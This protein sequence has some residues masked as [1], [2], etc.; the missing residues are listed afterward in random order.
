MKRHP[1]PWIAMNRA[2]WEW[3]RCAVFLVGILCVPPGCDDK[4]DA[5][6]QVSDPPATTQSAA[7]SRPTTQ[8]LLE[9]T[10]KKQKIGGNLIQLTLDVPPTWHLTTV[11]GSTWIEGEAPHGD[12]RIQIAPHGEILKAEAIAAMERSARS[13]AATQPESLE[14]VPRRDIGGM[15]AK[16]ERREIIRNLAIP[17]ENGAIEHADRVDWTIDAFIPQDNAFH[18]VTLNFSGLSLKQY[19]DDK[20]FLE[21]IIRSLHYDAADGAFP[22]EGALR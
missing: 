7:A 12:V 6:P 18:I 9:A 15:A 17:R 21:Y 22:G 3:F 13:H 16:M 10:R 20:E 2:V 4:R 14:I 19:N 5:I 8:Q 1:N 11:G